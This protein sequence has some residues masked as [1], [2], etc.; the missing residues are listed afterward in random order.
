MA[1]IAV[2]TETDG[3]I[4]MPSN[5][6]ALYAMKS[7]IG[8]ISQDGIVPISSRADTAGPMTKS[9]L[10]LANLLDV[11][12]DTKRN[13]IPKGGF[14]SC[15]VDSWADIKVGTLDPA[16]WKLPEAVIKPD[17]GATAQMVNPHISFFYLYTNYFRSRTFAQPTQKSRLLLKNITLLRISWTLTKCCWEVKAH[18]I[19][20]SVCFSD[21]ILFH[22]IL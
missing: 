11:I 22:G 1:P 16:N 7:T 5:R 17:A 19:Q 18:S 21:A 10:D 14:K 8:L 2:G 12:A 6:A 15:L 9:A 13:S 20:L 4:V 3:S